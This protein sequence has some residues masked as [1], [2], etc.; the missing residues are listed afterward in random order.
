MPRFPEIPTDVAKTTSKWD[1]R[2][3][4]EVLPISVL[5]DFAQSLCQWPEEVFAHVEVQASCGPVWLLDRDA[6]NQI[7]CVLIASCHLCRQ[8]QCATLLGCDSL[9]NEWLNFLGGTCT[10]SYL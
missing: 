2:N 6:M 8:P 1:G 10:P 7:S 9:Q 3:E 4:V 5:V